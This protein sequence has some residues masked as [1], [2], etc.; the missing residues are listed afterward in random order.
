MDI[1]FYTLKSDL[2]LQHINW[3]DL[4]KKQIAKLS[5]NIKMP[6]KGS[7]VC[8]TTSFPLT[9]KQKQMSYSNNTGNSCYGNHS[10]KIN[11]AFFQD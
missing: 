11:T 5:L 2:F 9:F 8:K 7:V 6:I 4:Y 3:Y 10:G 1:N